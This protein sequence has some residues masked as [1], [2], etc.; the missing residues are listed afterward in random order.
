MRKAATGLCLFQG[1]IQSEDNAP[2]TVEYSRRL[3][4]DPDLMPHGK[5]NQRLEFIPDVN[6]VTVHIVSPCYEPGERT[7]KAQRDTEHGDKLYFGTVKIGKKVVNKPQ[8]G[9]VATPAVELAPLPN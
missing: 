2:V 7:E 4:V 5:I 6:E 1:E 3:F 8:T 9:P